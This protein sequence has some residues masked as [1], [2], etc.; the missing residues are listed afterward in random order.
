M[1]I[2]VNENSESALGIYEF[3][4]SATL[5]LVQYTQHQISLLSR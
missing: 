1:H 2:G 3:V 4:F 5:T